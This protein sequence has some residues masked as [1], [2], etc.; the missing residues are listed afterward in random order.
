MKTLIMMVW[1]G[2]SLVPAI[3]QKNKKTKEVKE[4]KDEA[5]FQQASELFEGG[6]KVRAL[7]SFQQ[8]IV[9][10]PKSPLKASAHYN[11]GYLYFTLYKYDS[12]RITFHQILDQ[13]YNER[14][15]NDIMEPYKLYKHNTCRMLAEIA[16]LQ[17]DYPQAERYIE[18]FDKKFPYQHFC[19]NE[20]SAYDMY[21]AMMLAKV[22]KGMKKTDLAIQDLLPYVFDDGLA[23]NE[24]V[25]DELID[26]VK[27]KYTSAQIKQE[28]DKAIAS[29][30]VQTKN[31]YDQASI[32]LFG[33][34]VPV[35][36]WLGEEDSK[37]TG[38]ERYKKIIKESV[39]FERL[40]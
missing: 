25:V 1:L 4:T 6:L 22:H 2:I 30:S 19:G 7:R 33:I 9:A 16:L 23:S 13:P 20:W 3:A 31:K 15:A 5:A 18:M 17:E 28:L 14:D 24:A 38:V 27:Q 26:L 34:S 10:Y 12:A 11:I 8:F 29:V 35:R 39:F 21:K 36:G 37:V 32:Q 40:Q